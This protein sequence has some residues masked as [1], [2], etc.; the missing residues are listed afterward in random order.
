MSPINV[1]TVV[2][3]GASPFGAVPTSTKGQLN[4]MQDNF[5]LASTIQGLAFGFHSRGI[6]GHLGLQALNTLVILSS[7]QQ[8]L[9]LCKALKID[10]GRLL[11]T[12]SMYIITPR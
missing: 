11:G 8:G 1:D 9:F 7:Q 6:A 4:N 2:G 12:N 10:S 3:V 5:G